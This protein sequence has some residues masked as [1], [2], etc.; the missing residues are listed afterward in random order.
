[1]NRRHAPT[2]SNLEEV[3]DEETTFHPSARQHSYHPPSSN[4]SSPPST[5]FRL[6]SNYSSP[7]V[8]V[9]PSSSSARDAPAGD[10]YTRFIQRYR[11]PLHPHDSNRSGDHDDQPLQGLGSL[12]EGDYSDDEDD[13]LGMSRISLK[14]LKGA[15]A[16]ETIEPTNPEERERLEWQAMLTSVL[17]GD[18]LKSEK[19]RIAS[20]LEIL[21]TRDH[22]RHDGIWLGLR[23]NLS[24]TPDI[25]A[26]KLIDEKRRRYADNLYND[27]M[28][29]RIQTEGSPDPDIPPPPPLEQVELILRR[30]DAIEDLYPTFKALY[31]DRP[32]YKET[33]FQLRRDAL[34]A[35][36]NIASAVRHQLGSLKQWTG[37]DTLDITH[38]SSGIDGISN[39]SANPGVDVEIASSFVERVLKEESM[40]RMLEKKTL[41]TLNSF[42]S[43]T[44]EALVEYAETFRALNLPMFK[45]EFVQLVSFPS[46]LMEAILRV[47]LGYAAKV[48]DPEPMMIDQMMDDFRIAIGLACT[49][50][51][52]YEHHVAVDPTGNWIFP[53][54][55]TETYDAVVFKA[56]KYLF[57]LINMRY[58]ITP[59]ED[60]D[61]T[62]IHAQLFDEVSLRLTDGSRVVAEELWYGSLSVMFPPF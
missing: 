42:L 20:A 5:H 45:E 32:G 7:A 23:A 10:I 3:D 59:V 27:I 57:R 35:W 11:A 36:I 54:S 22:G 43:T 41:S 49:I 44:R 26:R 13:R 28:N 17:D 29:F 38:P 6:Q 14:D 18:V 15:G 52:E 60:I 9:A 34:T 40:H 47:R 55:I 30:L 1:M 8:L 58:K 46:R 24:G 39:S 21:S 51:N 53:P 37:S 2:L 61:I 48:K 4:V 16:D 25:E 62:G 33:A 50:R 19:T 12:L 56:V 31:N